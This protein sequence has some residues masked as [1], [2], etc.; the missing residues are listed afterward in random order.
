MHDVHSKRIRLR[1]FMVVKRTSNVRQILLLATSKAATGLLSMKGIA[2]VNDA[3]RVANS[4]REAGLLEEASASY[5][6]VLGDD[7]RGFSI[8]RCAIHALPMI[9]NAIIDNRLALAAVYRIRGDDIGYLA[10]HY[11]RYHG[12]GNVFVPYNSFGNPDK[13]VGLL[14]T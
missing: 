7:A 9:R 11:W 14:S 6:E 13:T 2:A 8:K 12:S 5:I 1:M 10:S 3:C 4:L